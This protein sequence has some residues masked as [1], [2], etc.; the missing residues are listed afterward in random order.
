MEI[1][2]NFLKTDDFDKLESIIMGSQFP[3]YH[4]E[5]VVSL[6]DSHKKDTIFSMVHMLYE[7]D[8]PTNDISM[9]IMKPILM[10]IKDEQPVGNFAGTLVRVK[11]N[12]YPN[13]NKFIEHEMHRDYDYNKIPYQACLF[14]LNTCNGYTKFEDG[15]KVE[16]VRNRALLFDP[17]IRHCSTNTTDQSRIVNINFNYI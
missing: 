5:S 15:T 10:R 9:E 12:S 2:D 8:R 1:I 4:S 16:S 17:T 6:E 14:S 7:N 13:Q 11:I 3:W